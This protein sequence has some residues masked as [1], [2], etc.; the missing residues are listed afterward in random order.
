MMFIPTITHG[1]IFLLYR[2]RALLG[3]R[4]EEAQAALSQGYKVI[5][6]A[7]QPAGCAWIFTRPRYEAQPRGTKV[8]GSVCKTPNS[9]RDDRGD[10]D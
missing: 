1:G 7:L 6:S 3:D 8:K 2:E 10:D 4:R 5:K 9:T